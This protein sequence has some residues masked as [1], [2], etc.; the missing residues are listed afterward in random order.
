LATI[1]KRK[2]TVTGAYQHHGGNLGKSYWNYVR[3]F[4]QVWIVVA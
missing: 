2:L 1:A 3:E 4:Q